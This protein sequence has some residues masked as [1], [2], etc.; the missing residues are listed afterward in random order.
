MATAHLHMVK[1]SVAI[2]IGLAF[3]APLLAGPTPFS[4]SGL[5]GSRFATYG[6]TGARI[7][8][9]GWPTIHTNTPAL[10]IS[11]NWEYPF[12][13]S[14]H[15][16]GWGGHLTIWDGYSPNIPFYWNNS[17]WFWPRS[18]VGPPLVEIARRV[19]PALLSQRPDP[20]PPPEPPTL[21]ELAHRALMER[22]YETASLLFAEIGEK[23]RQTAAAK[24]EGAA[25]AF[26]ED[27]FR[28]LALAGA[29]HF[30]EATEMLLQFQRAGGP[31]DSQSS[32]RFLGSPTEMRRIVNNSVAWAHSRNAP[33][34]WRLVAFLMDAEGR[35][36]QAERMRDRAV[37]LE[38]GASSP[39]SQSPTE[40]VLGPAWYHM[41]APPDTARGSA[42]EGEVDPAPSKP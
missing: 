41:P 18:Y 29:R 1:L 26:P 39:G 14:P 11:Y 16:M 19:D 23:L 8:S 3:A 21:Q 22:D 5:H 40:S 7:S 28:A 2:V 32:I 6:S 30:E 35:G 31:V 12:F 34:A 24:G 20:P 38:K 17:P 13:L 42:P 25:T 10:G 4:K 15:R 33:Q 27:L 37:L 9:N 36:D